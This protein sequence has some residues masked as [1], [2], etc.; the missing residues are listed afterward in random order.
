MSNRPL[1][2]TI[3]LVFILL[4]VLIWLVLGIVIAIN[5]H[6]ELRVKATVCVETSDFREV[7]KYLPQD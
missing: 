2:V 3:T 4:N 7:L 5:A 1:T 6:P